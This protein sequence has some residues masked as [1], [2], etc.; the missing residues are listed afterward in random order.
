MK[1]GIIGA[2]NIATKMASTIN[3][4]DGICNYAIASRDLQKAETFKETYGFIKAYGSYEGLLKDPND[5]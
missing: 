1:V 3:A 5:L 2:G 4:L